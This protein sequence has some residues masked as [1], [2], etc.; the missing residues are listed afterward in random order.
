[1]RFC[2]PCSPCTCFAWLGSVI[3]VSGLTSVCFAP[4][5]WFGIVVCT[6]AFCVILVSG[7]T[8]VCFAPF[9]WFGIVVWPYAFCAKLFSCR[10][11]YFIVFSLIWQYLLGRFDG[12]YG[13][14]FSVCITYLL[15]YV[16]LPYSFAYSYFILSLVDVRQSGIW[17]DANFLVHPSLRR[18]TRNLHLQLESRA[19]CTVQKYRSG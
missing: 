1:M 13:I 9:A 3:L 15:L 12:L 14:L 6:Y 10:V 4:F 5:A 19:P 11:C 18:L 7:L 17:R 16:I 2:H 8:S